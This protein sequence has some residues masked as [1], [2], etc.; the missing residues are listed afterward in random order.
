[1]AGIRRPSIRRSPSWASPALRWA[2]RRPA[3]AASPT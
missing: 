1:V 2:P 3:C